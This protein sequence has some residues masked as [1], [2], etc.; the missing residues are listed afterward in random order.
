MV[1]M[2]VGKKRERPHQC[3]PKREIFSGLASREIW[4]INPPEIREP[5]SGYGAVLL[6]C[7]PR[8]GYSEGMSAFRPLRS[9]QR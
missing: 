3:R 8:E 9:F 6:W 2:G 7:V 4:A 5:L 1:R